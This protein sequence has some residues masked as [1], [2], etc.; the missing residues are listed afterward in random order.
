MLDAQKNKRPRLSSDS[1]LQNKNGKPIFFLYFSENCD[2]KSRFENFFTALN[3][4]FFYVKSY[5]EVWTF[6]IKFFLLFFQMK[7]RKIKPKIV[8]TP[9]IVS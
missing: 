2:S 7:L 5:D 6:S 8:E 3:L 9:Q 4:N 1:Y